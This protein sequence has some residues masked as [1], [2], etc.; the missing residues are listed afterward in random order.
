MLRKI[1]RF[2]PIFISICLLSGCE[3]YSIEDVG[4]IQVAGYDYIDEEKTRGTISVPEYSRFEAGST[5]GEKYY[6]ATGEMLKEIHAKLQGM[7][8]K[9]LIHGKVTVN[10]YNEEL[11]ENDISFLLDNLIRD[12]TLGREIYLA[13]VD[14]S[15]K[16][17]IEGN[18]S[19]SE[20]TARYIDGLIR[21]NIKENF[22]TTNL[23]QFLYAYSAEGMDGF[24]PLLEKKGDHVDIKGIAFF[25]N[26][27]YVHSVPFSDSFLFKL[28]NENIKYGNRKVE[29]EGHDYIIEN[30]GSKVKYHAIDGLEN[31]KFRVEISLNGKLNETT[32]FKLPPD[33]QLLTKLENKLKKDLEED[34]LN[35]VEEFQENNIDPLGFGNVLKSRVRGFDYNQWKQIYPSA[36]I[37][38]DVNV[39]ILESGI[40]S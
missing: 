36:E 19:E 12:A 15:S 11:A 22:P 31:P 9:P 2:V 33:P 27:R 6:T 5:T 13:V 35:M 3:I 25:K 29:Y 39:E 23:H 8:S 28:M 21:N 40:S 20:R 17:M 14:G 37:E 10:L 38:V 32:R 18:Y 26:G 16:E 7:S 1:C 34:C 4:I 24:L 30:I